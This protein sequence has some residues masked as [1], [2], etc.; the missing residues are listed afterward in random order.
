MGMEILKFRQCIFTISFLFGPGKGCRP[1]FEQN[2]IPITQ[3]YAVQSLLN[4]WPMG[5]IA[6]LRKQF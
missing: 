3:E 5:H 6:N 4:K 2:L 1:S